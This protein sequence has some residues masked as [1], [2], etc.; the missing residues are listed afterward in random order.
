MYY[1][2]LQSLRSLT[3][4]ENERALRFARQAISLDPKFAAAYGVALACYSHRHDQNWINDDDVAE[5]KKYVVRAVEVGADDAFALSWAAHF[6]GTILNDPRTNDTIADQAIAVNP[7]LS[8]AWRIRAWASGRLGRHE[9]ALQ[10]FH[11]AMR[12]N[13]LDP[14]TFRAEAGLA[15][16]HFYLRRFDDALS[17]VTK[18]LARQKDFGPALRMAMFSYSMLGRIDEAQMMLARLREAGAVM[19]ISQVVKHSAYNR[20]EDVELRIEACRIIGMPE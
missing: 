16:T 6:A 9:L 1:R 7:N 11:Y 8:V 3:R 14:D 19:T 5:G 4:V 12:L 17:W 20:K 13:P 18:S 15:F 10:Q 2:A